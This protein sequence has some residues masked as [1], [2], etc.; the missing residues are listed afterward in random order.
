MTETKNFFTTYKDAVWKKDAKALINLYSPEMVAF[1]MW[2][3]GFYGSLK[4]WIPEMEH[5]LGSLGEERVQVDF[6]RI[7]LHE[8]DA[9]GFVSGYISFK[10]IA[11]DGRV[12]REMTNRIS[13]GFTKEN[14]DW[15]VVHQHISAPVRSSDLTAVLEL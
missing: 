6:D 12:L 14:G 3:Q 5:W 11:P 10:A 13:V 9:L 7:R 15:K 1:D 8:S 4:E 2:D